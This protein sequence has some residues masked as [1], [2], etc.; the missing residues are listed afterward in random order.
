[1]SALTKTFV[2][3]LVIVS[4]LQTAGLV[5]YINAQ[6][7]SQKEVDAARSDLNTTKGRLNQTETALRAAEDREAKNLGLVQAAVDAR[8]K[9]EADY[10]Q[11]L[12]D[13]GARVADLNSRLTLAQADTARLTEALKGAEN[14]MGTLQQLVTDLRSSNDTALTN[15]AQM[16]QQISDLT[17]KLEVTERERRFFA[18][19]LEEAR[20][21]EAKLTSA[22][23]DAGI[24]PQ[25][26]LASSAG[27]RAG[28]PN[29]NGV[30]REVRK[31][32]PL[33]YATISVGSSD[34]VSKGMEF[35]IVDRDSGA[36]MGILKVESVEPNEA[37][38][39]IRG[40]R[41]ADIRAGMEVK[42]QL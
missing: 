2:L 39:Q 27:L 4:L 34:N 16:S 41:I 14:R 36:F 13:A 29:I 23:K 20:G 24:S 25:Q 42:T 17:N 40:E 31:I 37:A 30:I 6:G 9:S 10:K 1:M 5:V 35:K 21:K 3:L 19:Q 32:G 33:D 7:T 12:A 11:K 15:A 18:E 28:A 8:N 38:G 26:V 22:L